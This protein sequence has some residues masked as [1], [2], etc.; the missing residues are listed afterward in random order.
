MIPGGM[1]GI[2]APGAIIEEGYPPPLRSVGA[3]VPAGAIESTMSGWPSGRA[4]ESR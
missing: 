1:G 3:L 4:R 2:T